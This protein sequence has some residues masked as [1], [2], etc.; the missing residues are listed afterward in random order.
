MMEVSVECVKGRVKTKDDELEVCS[1]N[2]GLLQPTRERALGLLCYRIGTTPV[3]AMDDHA[4]RIFR[5]S[6]PPR[7]LSSRL[8]P[9]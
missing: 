9:S 7:H 5:I 4:S 6:R 2:R 1:E 8:K 3:V